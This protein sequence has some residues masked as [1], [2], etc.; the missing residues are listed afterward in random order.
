MPRA[1][2]GVLARGQRPAQ[3]R[4]VHDHL[5]GPRAGP[6]QLDVGEVRALAG[7]REVAG[8]RGVEPRPV[9]MD[10]P[11]AGRVAVP[12]GVVGAEV[13][14]RE[15][16][17]GQHVARVEGQHKDAPALDVLV[18]RPGESAP[19]RRQMAQ[20]RS[21]VGHGRHP[22]AHPAGRSRQWLGAVPAA[23]IWTA[24]QSLPPAV[25]MTAT[26]WSVERR[27]APGRP[28][29][30]PS[31]ERSGAIGA[32]PGEPASGQSRPVGWYDGW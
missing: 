1:Q 18:V 22:T 9:D 25:T 4:C 21:E 26:R 13:V 29:R 12:Q 10:R 2:G 8:T 6:G 27:T 31:R 5:E 24:C 19:H 32:E 15:D 17:Q 16:P 23:R 11:A 30:A 20:L 7:R 14:L 28:V 3:G